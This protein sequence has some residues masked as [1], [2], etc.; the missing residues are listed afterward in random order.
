MRMSRQR[1]FGTSAEV[2]ARAFVREAGGH[3]RV[4][5][6][7]LP[8]SPDIANRR[9]K[10]AIFVHGC[11][12]HAHARCSRASLPRRNRLIWK[13]KLAE[14]RLRD[15]RVRRGLRRLGFRVVTI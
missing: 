15:Q 5:N 6:R 10:W 14:N 4:H 11:F 1:Q 2:I 13:A 8:G 7:D 9:G 12:W 3:Y